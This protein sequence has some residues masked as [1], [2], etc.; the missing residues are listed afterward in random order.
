MPAKD[1]ILPEPGP[2]GQD[3]TN[4]PTIPSVDEDPMFGAAFEEAFKRDQAHLRGEAPEEPLLDTDADH[5]QSLPDKTETSKAGD[6]SDDEIDLTAEP[7][8]KTSELDLLDE[9]KKEDVEEDAMADVPQ[10]AP[11][12]SADWKKFR[13]KLAEERA[14]RKDREAK[15]A[16]FESSKDRLTQYEELVKE[17]DTL[18]QQVKE[19]NILSD[20]AITKDIDE[21]IVSNGKAAIAGLSEQ[22]AQ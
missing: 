12:T 3:S 8:D 22:Q 2:A 14:L 6:K 5:A 19:A 11:K 18:A 15:L 17:R 10:A 16:E 13:S 21:Q 9:E 7:D 4:G 1:A 20:P